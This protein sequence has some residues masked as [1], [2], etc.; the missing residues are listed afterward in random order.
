M[1]KSHAK[2][3]RNGFVRV[4]R[5]ETAINCYTRALGFVLSRDRDAAVKILEY[6]IDNARQDLE[7]A[8]ASRDAKRQG[9]TP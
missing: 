2:R 9:V 8:V 3:M 7:A 6:H 1:P 4:V 5:A